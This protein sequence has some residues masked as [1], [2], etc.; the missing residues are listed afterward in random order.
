VELE[1]LGNSF[2]KAF[3]K[4]LPPEGKEVEFYFNSYPAFRKKLRIKSRKDNEKKLLEKWYKNT[5]NYYHP[6]LKSSKIIPRTTPNEK[7]IKTD[8][9]WWTRKEFNYNKV[10]SEKSVKSEIITNYIPD[11]FLRHGNRYPGYPNLPKTWQDWKELEDSFEPSTLRDE[12]RWTRICIQYCDTEDEKVLEELK[13][14]LMKMNPIQRT[15][16]VHT[17]WG[18]HGSIPASIKLDNTIQQFD[19]S[20]ARQLYLMPYI[21]HRY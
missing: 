10:M 6:E 21:Y 11:Y 1:D 16:M 17:Y 8:H 2:W 4:E 15:V 20:P 19:D 5:P 14:W 9:Y 13:L 18:K 3:Q 12:I 7:L